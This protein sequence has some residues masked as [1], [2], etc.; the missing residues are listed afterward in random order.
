MR[1]SVNRIIDLLTGF[2]LDKKLD[3]VLSM[4]SW[5]REQILDYQ[6]QQFQILK[7]HAQRS[8]IY[9]DCLTYNLKDFPVF[10][11][12]F[13]KENYEKFLTKI[14]K[15]Y[16]Y[17]Y[18]SGST[19][20]PMKVV[21]SK[22]MMLHKRI[23]H[24]KM[25]TW[26]GLKREDSE[27]FIGG[28]E[29][30]FKTK[31]YYFLKNKVFLS[32]NNLDESTIM[33]YIEIINRKKPEI[34]FS[35]PFA[36]NLIVNYAIKHHITIH[37]PKLIY[38]GAETIYPHL[39]N[40]IRKFFSESY[41]INEY[42][43]TE[44]NI[45]VTCPEGKLH[46]DEDTIIV[47][48]INKD[49]NGIG[50]LLIT[51]LFSY[52][53]PLIRYPLGD[54]IRLSDEKCDCGRNTKII[55]YIEGR[56]T[57]YFELKTGEKIVFTGN[58]NKLA[59]LCDNIIAYQVIHHINRDETI[60]NYIIL[61]DSKPINKDLISGFFKKTFNLNVSFRVVPSIEPEESGKYKRIKSIE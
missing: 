56:V 50:D 16:R 7:N 36:L 51:N 18:T 42:W 52:D 26:Y 61:D 14:R 34:L 37:Q 23:S 9:K 57:E 27:I 6:L 31:I 41:L 44:A 25:L 45:A 4:D 38:T 39:Q 20:I 30:D 28:K 11:K 29:I 59:E 3:S 43:S 48:V 49:K 21:V 60:F 12:E 24:L 19:G 22:E 15:P 58:G 10:S 1:K 47:E 32:S 40:E 2:A 5:T 55:E 33:K 17:I 54:R 8:I 13:I 35:Y 46:I 53:F